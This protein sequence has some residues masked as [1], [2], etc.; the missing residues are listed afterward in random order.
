MNAALGLERVPLPSSTPD[1]HAPAT[2]IR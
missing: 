2:P 1:P